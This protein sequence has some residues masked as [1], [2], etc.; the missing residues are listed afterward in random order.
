MCQCHGGL[1]PNRRFM[2]CRG[3]WTQLP[4]QDVPRPVTASEWTQQPF[5]DVQVDPTAGPGV[6]VHGGQ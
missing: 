5:H 4:F 3:Q 6:T 1:G 2:M